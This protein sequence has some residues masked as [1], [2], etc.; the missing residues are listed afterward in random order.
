MQNLKLQ[1]QP[2]SLHNGR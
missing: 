2:L 1:I